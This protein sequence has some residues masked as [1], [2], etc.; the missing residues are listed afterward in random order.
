[1]RWRDL[2]LVSVLYVDDDPWLLEIGKMFLEKNSTFTVDTALS[3]QDALD[4]LATTQYNAI[5]SDYQMPGI[6]GIEFLKIIR[7]EFGDIPFILY[8]G[9][10]REEVVIE[11]LNNG[12]D[13]YIQKGGD[14][15]AQFAELGHI[16]QQAVKCQVAEAA[17]KHREEQLRTLINSMP[18]IVCFKDGEGRWIEANDF[19]LR[20]FQIEGISYP[21]KKDSDLAEFSPLCRDVF[22]ACEKSDKETWENKVLTRYEETIPRPDGTHMT[23]DILKVPLFN[24]DGSP[25]GLVII[26]CD[27]TGRRE[28]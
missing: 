15:K 18:N 2:S 5:V 20:L 17:F 10:G 14:A 22:L 12:V 19:A 27:I 4:R 25:K 28:S 8:T 26:G 16:I 24:H 7:N 3:A 21:G 1:M 9:R 13:F 23:F 6:D 11:A